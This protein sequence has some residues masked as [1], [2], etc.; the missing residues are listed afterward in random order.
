MWHFDVLP[1][2]AIQQIGCRLMI[3]VSFCRSLVPFRLFSDKAMLTHQ[4]PHPMLA[5]GFPLS[6]ILCQMASCPYV[7]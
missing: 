3:W 6:C 7:W 2:V 4:A 5:A 1:H